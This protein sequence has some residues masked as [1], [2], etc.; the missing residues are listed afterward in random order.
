MKTLIATLGLAMAAFSVQAQTAAPLDAQ[1]AAAHLSQEAKRPK[2]YTKNADPV[3]SRIYTKSG[4][5]RITHQSGA[6]EEL[7]YVAV[8]I[9]FVVGK[10]QLLDSVSRE[11][12]RK[13]A[14][15][16]QPLMAKGSSFCI[17]GHASPEGNAQF[18]R[19]LSAERADRILSILTE[20]Y[21]LDSGRLY[22][23]GLGSTVAQT[24]NVSPNAGEAVLQEYRRVLVVKTK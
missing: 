12:L 6:V 19:E 14:E 17:E 13:T 22:A 15:I 9:L 3:T 18:N 21:G 16:L 5:V 8:P 2:L 11:N 24:E 10:D 7:P 20:T 4:I 23:R 1:A